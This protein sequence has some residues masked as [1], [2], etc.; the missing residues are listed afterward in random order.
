MGMRIATA[1]APSTPAP[2][3]TSTEPV[4]AHAGHAI[5][6]VSI[7]WGGYEYC[8]PCRQVLAIENYEGDLVWQA[9]RDTA[10]DCRHYLGDSMTT[11][12][13]T[14]ATAS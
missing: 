3:S 5:V 13:L 7:S 8:D 10:A 4:S 2:A 6:D 14:A 9:G 1:F 11:N 12:G